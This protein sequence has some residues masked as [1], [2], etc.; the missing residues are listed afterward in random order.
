MSKTQKTN[1]F[2]TSFIGAALVASLLSAPSFAQQTRWISDVLYVPMRKGPS[3]QHTI[4]HRGLKSGTRLS[5]IETQENWSQV[6]IPDGSTGW[7]PN[8]YLLEEPIAALKLEDAAK[9][10]QR[11]SERYQEASNKLKQL[12]AENESLKK[13]LSNSEQGSSA[14]TSELNQIKQISANAIDLN[15]N[16]QQLAKDHQLLQTELDV[17]R[18][19][20]ERL[21]KEDSQTWFV[22]GAGAV[23]LGVL[24][25]VI[26]PAL[27]PRR[28]RSEWG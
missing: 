11:S 21:K 2:K 17:A 15:D 4:L 9:K 7:V 1:T 20:N 19:E 13:Q 24:I 8:Q 25:T 14:L 28:R 27:R 18:A 10:A 23:L 26:L 3:N 16:Y 12:S 5:I 22:Y 6:R